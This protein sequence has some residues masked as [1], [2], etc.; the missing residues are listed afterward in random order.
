MIIKYTI[1]ICFGA[2]Y[3]FNKYKIRWL[4]NQVILV[5]SF[6]MTIGATLGI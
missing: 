5:I 3:L 1:L 6:E 2:R 4:P